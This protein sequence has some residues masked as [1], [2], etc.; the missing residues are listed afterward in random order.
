M[1]RGMLSRQPIFNRP[2]IWI[3][4]LERCNWRKA[5]RRGGVKRFTGIGTCFEYDL[6]AG[7]LSVHSPLRPLTPYAGAKTAAFMALSQ[8]LPRQGVEFAWC[9]LFYL[10]GEGENERR[11]VPYLRAKLM[12]GEPAELTSGRRR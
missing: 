12:A 6:A 9:R 11:L 10:Y 7:A 5:R 4:W 3:V 2:K 8:W 1:P